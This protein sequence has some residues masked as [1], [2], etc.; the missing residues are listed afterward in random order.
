MQHATHADVGPVRARLGIGR[1]GVG[2]G[3]GGSP[4]CMALVTR[5]MQ[6]RNWTSLDKIL[7]NYGIPCDMLQCELFPECSLVLG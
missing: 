2:A 4:A 1:K 3:G 5:H 7:R 6:R